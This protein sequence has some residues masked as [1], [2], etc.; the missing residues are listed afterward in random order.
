MFYTSFSIAIIIA[1]ILLLVRPK[2][3]KMGNKKSPAGKVIAF[4]VFI[5]ILTVILPM[6]FMALGLQINWFDS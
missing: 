4:I 3:F 2:F 5:A 1:I 6:I